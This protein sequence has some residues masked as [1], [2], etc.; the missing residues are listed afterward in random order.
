[1]EQQSRLQAHFKLSVLGDLI[2]DFIGRP[3]DDDTT[4]S[5]FN[6]I[7]ANLVPERRIYGIPGIRDT[8]TIIGVPTTE[9]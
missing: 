8:E 1:M 7:R 3:G 6:A 4:T 5:W 9:I 2:S